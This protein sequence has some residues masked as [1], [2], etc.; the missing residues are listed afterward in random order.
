[1][2]IRVKPPAIDYDGF[3]DTVVDER[4]A[5]INAAY[6]NGIHA[7]WKTR[8]QEYLNKKGNP[9]VVK[10]WPEVTHH[11]QKFLNLYSNPKEGSVQGPILENLRSRT[12]QLCP[13]CGE[14]GT[15]NTLDHYL[16][17]ESYPEFSITPANL[18][19]MCDICQGKKKA[20]TVNSEKK[21]FFLHPY[22]DEFTDTQVVEL[23]IG[24]PLDAPAM[25]TL[26]P[27]TSLDPAQSALVSRHL[28]ELE[29]ARRY[30]HFFR[31]EY[32]RLLRLTSIMRLQKQDVRGQLTNFCTMASFKSVNS[33]QHVFYAGVLADTELVIYLEIG[34]LPDFL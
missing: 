14:D 1:M 23:E 32:L 34:D 2:V 13:A 11:K 27:H 9:E 26:R 33:W 12:L 7:D 29:I 31:D 30:Y 18:S 20:K 28:K 21:R 5:G 6:F 24:R 16:P 15:P 19:P 25:I 3:V 10:P 22:F 17:Q 4:Q 8:T